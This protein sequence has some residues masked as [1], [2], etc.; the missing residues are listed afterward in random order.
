MSLGYRKR[1]FIQFTKANTP[2]K[3]YARVMGLG[4]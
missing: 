4:K 2:L 3:I 1:K